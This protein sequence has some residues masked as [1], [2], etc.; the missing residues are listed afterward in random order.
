MSS[1]SRPSSRWR[2]WMKCYTSSGMSSRRSRRAGIS[3]RERRSGDSRG[4]RGTVPRPIAVPRSRFVAAMTR[5]STL[6]VREEPT[7]LDLTTLQGAQQLGLQRGLEIA[8][9]RPGTA[10]PRWPARSAP[11]RACVAPVKAPFSC[12]NS[13]LLDLAWRQGSA[14]HGDQRPARSAGAR[15]MHARAISSLPSRL[16]QQQHRHVGGRHLI[17]LVSTARMAAL[18]PTTSV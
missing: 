10:C 12:P 9:S 18:R 16:A 14:V 4:P 5:T 11:A 13:S 1:T 17:D 6:C 2:D 8:R 3:I 15:R 7:P